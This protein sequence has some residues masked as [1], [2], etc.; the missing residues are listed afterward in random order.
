MQHNWLGEKKGK[1]P[2]LHSLGNCGEVT[3][4]SIRGKRSLRREKEAGGKG[5][6]GA[7]K[8]SEK[9]GKKRVRVKSV[10]A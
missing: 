2:S 6:G 1:V 8:K 4:G 3:R 5:K 10:D 9:R 7:K